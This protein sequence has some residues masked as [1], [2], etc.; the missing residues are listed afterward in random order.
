MSLGFF[1]IMTWSIRVYRN[2]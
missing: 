1:R 2:I